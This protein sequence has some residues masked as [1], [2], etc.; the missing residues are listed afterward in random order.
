[1]S[2]QSKSTESAKCPERRAS[3]H[4][5]DWLDDYDYSRVTAIYRVLRGGTGRTRFSCL[6][7]ALVGAV[8][9]AA[10]SLAWQAD[11]QARRT[12]RAK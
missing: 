3:T 8:N 10:L 1:M 12:E 7:L 11:Y 5:S 4:A 2:K 9:G 6:R